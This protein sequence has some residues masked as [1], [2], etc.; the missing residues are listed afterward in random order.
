MAAYLIK[1]FL[2][3]LILFLSLSEPRCKGIVFL[4]DCSEHWTK[5][6]R[7]AYGAIAYTSGDVRQI[8]VLAGAMIDSIT[9]SAA[10]TSL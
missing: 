8:V 10:S 2:I 1:H 3:L 4:V 5:H 7:F 6:D 9:T